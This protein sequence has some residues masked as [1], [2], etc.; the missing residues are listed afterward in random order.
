[1]L[2][3]LLVAAGG[4]AGSV[5]RYFTNVG[6]LRLMGPTFPWG[7]LAVNIVGSMLIGMFAELIMTKFSASEGL[8][9]L[10]VTGFLGGYTTFS[11]FSWDIIMMV[12]RGDGLWAL[13]YI[14]ASILISLMAVMAGLALVRQFS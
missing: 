10:L 11:A 1:M 3:V 13:V 2:N 7:T 6:M 14:A 5:A 12:N 4:A 8:R 9:L